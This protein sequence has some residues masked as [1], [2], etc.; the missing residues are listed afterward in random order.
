MTPDNNNPAEHLPRPGTGRP[1]LRFA[2]YGRVSTEDQQDPE[3]SRNWQI[4][5]ARILIEPA[6]G[7]IVEEFF[8]VG[9]SRS[10]PWRRRSE[11]TRLLEALKDP[12]RGFEAVV[13]GEP[14][15]A[16][17]GNQFGL[18]F[19]LFAHY[20]VQLWVPEV[21]GTIDPESD[22]HDLV[23]ALYGGMSKG[24][25][26][27]IKIRVRA[28]M[29]SQAA[30]EGRFLG[31]RP[32]YGY[33]LV[34]AGPH[35]NPG[36]AADGKRLNALA[37][38]L[39]TAPI[40]HRI[41][42]AY[43]EG[44]GLYAIAE[45]LTRDGIPSPSAYDR[46]RNKHRCGLA[47]S[48]AAV[49]VILSNPRYTGHQVWNKQRKDEVLIDVD[50]VALGHQTRM[51]WNDPTTWI[52]SDD[53]VHEPLIDVSTFQAAQDLLAAAGRRAVHRKPRR[54]PRDY[55]LTGLMFCGLCQRRMQASW[56]NGKP[57]YRC[58][59]PEQYALANRIEHPR[60]VYVREELI[61][62]PLD[63]WLA[64]AFTAPHLDTTIRAMEQSQDTGENRTLAAEQARRT[65][66]EADSK[67]TRY[68]A[69]LEQGIDPSLI[70][71]WTAEVTAAKT[72]AQDA[73]RRLG[74]V[75]RMTHDEISAIVTAAGNIINVLRH[76]DGQDK[77]TI[78]R[79]LGLRLTFH[80][81]PKTVI[82]EA[83]PSAIMYKTKC[84]RGDL[85]PHALSGTS[86]SS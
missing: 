58:V 13:I 51:R 27:R 83:S 4:A 56:N 34:D 20:G 81:D 21:G 85:N 50:D 17:Y 14:Q 37:P 59:F 30:T 41:F 16:F 63:T 61:L 10:I 25:R 29:A 6:G 65:I 39:A 5:R 75:H 64:T 9:L 31:G 3:A 26:N 76:A 15:R 7:V 74:D 57:H 71:T 11:A 70:A 47:W 23:M 22:A 78:Y 19:P 1:R 2:F 80:Q 67:L 77:A 44:A 42:T 73:L 24:E 8:D 69:A 18:T 32:P 82:A 36:K 66:T 62:P 49:R 40:V 35:P 33:R 52:W 68:R 54:T 84:P 60:S 28:A 43:L 55:A 79:Q 72:T 12:D 48:K 38:D 46:A 45:G 86:T 53:I